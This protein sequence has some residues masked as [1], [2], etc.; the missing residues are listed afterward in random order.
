MKQ[1]GRNPQDVAVT[2]PSADIAQATVTPDPRWQVHYVKDIAKEGFDASRAGV[3]LNIAS[4]MQTLRFGQFYVLN[5]HPGMILEAL[6][7]GAEEL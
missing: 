6:P 3:P 2:A 7:S 1:V 5:L 4:Q